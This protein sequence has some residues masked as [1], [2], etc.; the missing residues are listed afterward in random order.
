MPHRL[1]EVP[2]QLLLH[3]WWQEEMEGQSGVLQDEESGSGNHKEPGGDGLSH[4]SV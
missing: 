2:K 1:E 3:F 4:L